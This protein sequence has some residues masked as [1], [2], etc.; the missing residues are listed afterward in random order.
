M[1]E[2]KEKVFA[3]G[4]IVKKRDGSPDFVIAE[5][6]FKVQD[7]KNFLDANIKSG[8][9]NATVKQAKSG[10]YYAELNTFEPK[11]QA[12]NSATNSQGEIGF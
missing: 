10:K 4:L 1:N 7:F 2:Q 8:W 5:L 6:S 3:D 9:V 11:P 12:N